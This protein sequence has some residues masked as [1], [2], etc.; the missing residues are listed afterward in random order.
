MRIRAAGADDALVVAALAL[1]CAIH[2]GGVGEPG[3][4][5]RYARTWLADQRH[6][7][8]WL[9]EAD[10]DHAGFLQARVVEPLPRPLTPPEPELVVETFFVRTSHRGIGVGERLLAAAA[11]WARD[12]DFARVRMSAGP[13]TRPM[14]ERVGF[15]ADEAAYRME[16]R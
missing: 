10:E 3:F 2:R 15:S 6:L 9:A 7:P 14:V 11:Q 5:D 16:L 1:Q 13:H 4:L 8:V 12:G